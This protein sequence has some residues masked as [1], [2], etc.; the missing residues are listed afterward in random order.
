[1]E[2]KIAFGVVPSRRLGQSLGINNI[3]P[4]I[5]SYSCI[6]CQVGRTLNFSTERSVFYSTDRIVNE[7]SSAIHQLKDRGEAIDFLSFVPNGEPTLDIN[8]GKE[9]AALKKFNIPIAVITNAS[10]IWKEDVRYDLKEAD[11]VSIKIDTVKRDIWEKINRPDRECLFNQMLEGIRIF[12]SEFKGTLITETL[13]IKDV[14][15]TLDNL[16]QT[17]KFIS[18]IRPAIA[19]IGIPTR[20][21]AEEGILPPEKT[22][23]L[24]AYKIFTDFSIKTELITESGGSGSFGFTGN[25][26][27]DIVNT[28]SVHPMSETQIQELLKKA[29]AKWSVME[30][31]LSE[32]RIN[33]IKYKEERY[34]IKNFK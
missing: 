29:S 17:A 11:L 32:K 12:A 8:L 7:V 22:K 21:P 15:D 6:Y 34:Y 26:E 1:M 10:L 9:I 19:Y 4:K 27:N 24:Y 33:E 31:L 20:P 2:E 13:L 3:P 14:N 18:A 5:C 16:K 23:I 30:K 28:V 25:I